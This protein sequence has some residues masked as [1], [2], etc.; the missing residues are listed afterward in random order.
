MGDAGRIS[1]VA[2]ISGKS[3]Q[4]KCAGPVL[5]RRDIDSRSSRTEN[6]VG[7]G[8]PLNRPYGLMTPAA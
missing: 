5:C 3:D 2:V 8:V 1:D 6:Q 4:K 7:D